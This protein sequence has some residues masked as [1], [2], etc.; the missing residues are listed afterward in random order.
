[1][2]YA[3]VVYDEFFPVQKW[4]PLESNLVLRANE[5]L[6]AIVYIFSFNLKVFWNSQGPLYVARKL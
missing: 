1:M 5:H 6:L 3:C 4:E 2:F